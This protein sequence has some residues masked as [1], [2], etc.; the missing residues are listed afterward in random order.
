MWGVVTFILLVGKFWTLSNYTICFYNKLPC[1]ELEM[2][3]DAHDILC[4]KFSAQSAVWQHYLYFLTPVFLWWMVYLRL[5]SLR[6]A[7]LIVSSFNM[8]WEVAIRCLVIFVWVEIL[9]R[10]FILCF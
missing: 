4:F 9:V 8:V 7:W 10:Y 3:S 1:Y 2:I 6:V 5:E